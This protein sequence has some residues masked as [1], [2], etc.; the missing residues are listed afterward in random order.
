M[1]ITV[2][3]IWTNSKSIWEITDISNEKLVYK[4]WAWEF[5]WVSIWENL[6]ID[7]WNLKLQD[8]IVV[9]DINTSTFTW[10]SS[11]WNV[12]YYSFASWTYDEIEWEVYDQSPHTD[13]TA[14]IF[15]TPLIVTWPYD[16]VN[17]IDFNGSTDYV[18]TKV[19]VD[20]FTWAWTIGC[21]I[22]MDDLATDTDNQR[23]FITNDDFSPS[24]SLYIVWWK[25]RFYVNN[26]STSDSYDCPDCTTWVWYHC[27]MVYDG[28][29]V[30]CYIDWVLKDTL[31]IT[32][33]FSDT[34]IVTWGRYGTNDEQYYNGKSSQ[35]IVYNRALSAQEVENMS[36]RQEVY[37]TDSDPAWYN[38]NFWVNGDLN[39]KWY[40]KS[41]AGIEDFS[42]TF[43]LDY[44]DLW[45]TFNCTSWTAVNI[46]LTVANDANIPIWFQVDL[47][48]SWA[49]ALS[50]VPEATININGAS[51]TRTIPYQYCFATLIKTADLTYVINNWL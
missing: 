15:G 32:G 42:T 17:A 29:D 20:D 5:T 13:K 25:L 18:Q 12:L 46:W 14:E 9:N 11:E 38:G 10:V 21:M 35:Q 24:I 40:V 22:N 48:Q 27:M 50:I 1:S 51:T 44:E 47:I 37:F 41:L 4:D 23:I 28:T 45:K 6:E 36:N 8:D 33:D 43:D 2:S 19:T 3:N 39:V 26:G 16:W 34:E 49:W 31:T 7:S 30:K